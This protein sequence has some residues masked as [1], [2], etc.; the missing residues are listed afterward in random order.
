MRSYWNKQKPFA[1]EHRYYMGYKRCEETQQN[2]LV[3]FWTILS[4]D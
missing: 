3:R 4:F 2:F 1:I